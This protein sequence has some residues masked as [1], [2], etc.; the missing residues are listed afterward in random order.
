M[1]S[2]ANKRGQSVDKR[3]QSHDISANHFRALTTHYPEFLIIDLF[4]GI[5]LSIF[6]IFV[7]KVNGALWV[8]H[9]LFVYDIEPWS[10]WKGI[11]FIWGVLM[12]M[13]IHLLFTCQI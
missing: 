6:E 5:E 8:I 13:F 11:Y 7:Y 9:N 12:L 1:G 4:S 3:P 2:A 10:L